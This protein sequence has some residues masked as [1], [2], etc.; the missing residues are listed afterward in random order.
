MRNYVK[1]NVKVLVDVREEECEGWRSE[2]K[3]N[4]NDKTRLEDS[5]GGRCN[6]PA[7]EC[8]IS[9]RRS[10]HFR[11]FCRRVSC[12]PSPSASRA[13]L[14]FLVL[15]V[16]VKRSVFAPPPLCGAFAAERRNSWI[17][18]EPYFCRSSRLPRLLRQRHIKL[19]NMKFQAAAFMQSYSGSMTCKATLFRVHTLLRLTPDTSRTKG[20]APVMN[21]PQRHLLLSHRIVEIIKPEK[22]KMRNGK[23]DRGIVFKST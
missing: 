3:Y 23:E 6:L 22:R 13:E 18:P 8:L 21:S 19:L 14:F 16:N 2:W 4:G 1:H 11:L 7:N 10:E 9:H 5:L 20:W 12:P 17:I 15:R